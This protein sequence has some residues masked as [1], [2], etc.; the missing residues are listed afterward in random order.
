M[1]QRY[2]TLQE[3]LQELEA[4]LSLVFSLPAG[5]RHHHLNSECIQQRFAFLKNLLS[6]EIA[7]RPSKPSHLR[8]IGKRLDELETAFREHWNDVV[9]DCSKSVGHVNIINNNYL[10]T[11]SVCSCDESSVE[12]DGEATIDLTSPDLGSSDDDELDKPELNRP[13]ALMKLKPERNDAELIFSDEEIEERRKTNNN[14]NDSRHWR[15]KVVL[16]QQQNMKNPLR[17]KGRIGNGVC[18]EEKEGRNSSSGKKYLG[19]LI[20]GMTLGMVLMGA[21]AAIAMVGDSAS[22]YSTSPHDGCIFYT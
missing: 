6:A 19:A 21:G 8:H 7:S 15:Q 18:V 3:K 16:H 4:K 12:D 17:M 9:E 11:S 14:N 2:K 10:D 1:T 5:S 13:R 22:S 20:S